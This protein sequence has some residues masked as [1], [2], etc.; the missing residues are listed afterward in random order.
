M[1]SSNVRCMIQV[2]ALMLFLNPAHAEDVVSI[3]NGQVYVNDQELMFGRTDERV[4]EKILGPY[5]HKASDGS[6]YW[7]D[8][9]VEILR[10]AESPQCT[11]IFV[12]HLVEGHIK[13]IDTTN[14][15]ARFNRFPGKVFVEHTPIDAETELSKLRELTIDRSSLSPFGYAFNSDGLMYRQT[16]VAERVEGRR[17]KNWTVRV[18]ANDFQSQCD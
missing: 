4:Y 3:R 6:I 5:T 2:T 17:T 10:N 15:L 18:T 1:I 9:G 12:V 7:V 11:A 8:K 13:F 16:L 14:E